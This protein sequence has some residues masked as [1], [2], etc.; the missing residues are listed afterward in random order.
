MSSD[1]YPYLDIIEGIHT[2]AQEGPHLQEFTKALAQQLT[3][4]ITGTDLVNR[5]FGVQSALSLDLDALGRLLDTDRDLN[6]SDSSFRTDLMNLVTTIEQSTITGIQNALNDLMGITPNISEYPDVNFIEMYGFFRNEGAIR[7]EIPANYATYL[8]DATILVD[9]MKAAGIASVVEVGAWFVETFTEV[10][11]LEDF[12]LI[13][14]DGVFEESIPRKVAIID[15]AQLDV[16]ILAPDPV[17]DDGT[18]TLS[19]EEVF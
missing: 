7:V 10:I 11:T 4:F 1:I 6:Q 16:H 3:H 19:I 18:K 14:K 13:F 12:M 15:E 5:F 17:W 2:P 8:E 9:V